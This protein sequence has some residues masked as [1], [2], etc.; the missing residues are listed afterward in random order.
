VGFAAVL[1]LAAPATGADTYPSRPIKF[2]VPWPAGGIVDVRARVIAHRLGKAL[3]QQVIVENKPGAS[4]TIGATAVAR[5]APDG[6][7]LLFGT[8][9]DQAVALALMRDLPYDPEKDFVPVV[10]LG[11]SCAVLLV[12]PSLEVDSGAQL[13]A[14]VHRKPGQL[15]YAHSGIGTP[16]HL[17]AEQFKLH[18]KLDIA[19]VAYKGSGPALPDLSAGHVSLMFDFAPSSAPYVQSGKL[20]AL[21]TGCARRI[22]VYP[23]VPSAP[24]AGFPELDVPSWGGLFAPAGTPDAIVERLNREINRIQLSPDVRSHLAYAGAEIPIMSPQEFAEFIR[25]DR[26][27]WGDL[28]RQ[29]GVKPE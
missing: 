9:V 21:M 26:P 7:T 27:R 28:A 10:P 16:S 11:R 14:L 18:Q 5:A 3:G 25:K 8:F 1:L 15:T 23:D 2:I 6:Y 22:D 20:K 4:G 24:E 13:V 12:P 29:A 19:A 17:L